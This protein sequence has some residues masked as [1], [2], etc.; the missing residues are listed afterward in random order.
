M[1]HKN[2][3]F[4]WITMAFVIGLI[5]PLLIQD[6]MFMD[7]MLY[8]SVG[9]NLGNGIGTFWFP[10]FSLYGI[11]GNTAFHEH[12]PLVFG[13]QAVFFFVFG[14]SMYVE[15][16]YSFF[17]ALVTAY[18]IHELWQ[19]LVRGESKLTYNK[20]SWLPIFLWI[21]V[22]V[23][24]WSFQNNMQ[25][26][27]MGI[28]TLLAVITAL[29]GLYLGRNIILWLLASG[30]FI[31]LA[32]LSKGVPGIFPMGVVGFYW[33]T[34]RRISFS[35]AAI[36]S[37]ILV[38]T[39]VL[40]YLVLLTF[41]QDAY[42]SL[43]IYA[44]KRLMGRVVHAHTV[45]NRF[46]IFQ[47]L[48]MELLPALFVSLVIWLTSKFMQLKVEKAKDLQQKV[49]LLILIGCSGSMPLVLTKVQKGFYFAHSIPFFAL[50]LA[51]W[52]AP[53]VVQ[54]MKQITPYKTGFKIVHII[55][56]LFLVSS[57]T[58]SFMQVGKTSREK[59]LLH[60]VHLLTN[61]LPT[62]T[63]INIPKTM[64]NDW[65]LQCYLIRYGNISVDPEVESRSYY[66]IEKKLAQN[67][68]WKSFAKVDIPL[69]RY[70][71]YQ[72]KD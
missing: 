58:Y 64:W 40:I 35:K 14:N 70:T 25:E 43:I 48:F 15:R 45:N 31:F 44:K 30:G 65:S 51:L 55:S 68:D 38:A 22:P 36:Y 53:V 46:Y 42:D 33:L 62:N 61:L 63:V 69:K 27:T 2:L 24:F 66:L 7:G 71:L 52:V 56:I 16:F 23:T 19:F 6:G 60:D 29:K 54:W 26:N 13:I 10:K 59:N 11:A 3:P 49:F 20:I 28:F 37:L 67:R 9:K 5:L 57:I 8:T 12:P 1:R 39:P 50:G 21:I 17:T 34:T 47:K 72:R 4:W 41:H 18:L 32:S